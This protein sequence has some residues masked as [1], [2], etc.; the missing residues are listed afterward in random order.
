MRFDFRTVKENLSNPDLAEKEKAVKEYP[1]IRKS[2]L[3]LQ[4]PTESIQPILIRLAYLNQKLHIKKNQR[5]SGFLSQ[6]TFK[7]FTVKNRNIFLL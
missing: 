7:Q 4:Q 1:S 3:S 2:Y 5:I 6:F